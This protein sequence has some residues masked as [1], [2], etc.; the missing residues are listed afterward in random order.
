MESERVSAPSCASPFPVYADLVDRLT[1]AHKSAGGERDPAVAHVLGTCAGYSYADA[2]TVATMMARLGLAR[3]ACVRISAAVPSMLVFSTAYILQSACGRVVIVSYRGTEGDSFGNWLGDAEVG[4]EWSALGVPAAT[5]KVRVHAGFHRNVRTTWLSIVEQLNRAVEGRSLLNPYFRVK[6][7]L[8]AL[9][10]TG[11]SLGGA[12]ALLF[13]LRLGG[14]PAHRAIFS[15][16]RA[17][18]TFGQPLA[19]AGP[20]PKAVAAV[21]ARVFRHVTPGD[22]IPALPPALWGTLQ[23]VG[24]EY[25]YGGDEWQPADAPTA[26]MESMRELP[27]ALFAFLAKEKDRASFRYAMGAHG[28]HQYLAALRPR[29]RVTEYGDVDP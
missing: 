16:L 26:Q 8:E 6:R 10:V 24:H 29:D 9:Y 14:N 22:P 23:H 25:R 5:E 11:H 19:L 17:V 1:R 2:D 15:K 3:H 18:Y 13:A 28:A 12:M 21:G 4:T 7:P 20:L 27:R